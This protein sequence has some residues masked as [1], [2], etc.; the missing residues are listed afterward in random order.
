MP[1]ATQIP[2]NTNEPPKT[3]SQEF[4]AF[5]EAECERRL[6]SGA[7]FNQEQFK[8]AVALVMGKL[9]RIELGDDE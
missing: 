9:E 4:A 8:Q 6:N 2:P 5:C 3:P 7:E 1:D